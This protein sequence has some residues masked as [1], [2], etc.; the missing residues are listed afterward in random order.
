MI[1]SRSVGLADKSHTTPAL[2]YAAAA[3]S[4]VPVATVLSQ[5]MAMNRYMDSA[6]SAWSSPG[7]GLVDPVTM[8]TAREFLRT[9]AASD[10][11]LE[12]P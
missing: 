4:L 9:K 1:R 8:V 7:G 2:V 12:V 11:H 5:I 6:E 10:N 3:R